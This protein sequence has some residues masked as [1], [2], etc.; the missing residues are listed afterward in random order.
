VGGTHITTPPYLRRALSLVV[1]SRVLYLPPQ[2]AARY[3]ASLHVVTCL[4][5][6]R[7]LD[8]P[9]SRLVVLVLLV[10]VVPSLIEPAASNAEPPPPRSNG[11]AVVD[12][13]AS[14]TH[15]HHHNHNDNDNDDS[16]SFS[17]SFAF[18]SLVY[19]AAVVTI[20]QLLLAFVRRDRMATTTTATTT[21]VSCS[22]RDAIVPNQ[23]TADAESPSHMRLVRNSSPRSLSLSLS[24]S[25]GLDVAA[26]P[27]C[28]SA[29]RSFMSHADE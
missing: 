29:A 7:W 14:S 17:L 1:D 22:S 3:C 9:C 10:L 18:S 11:R 26:S 25:R 15:H 16:G 4:S 24:R 27:C 6:M 12:A 28:A 19:L 5:F 20:V 8:R 23:P 2:L 13:V 21:N